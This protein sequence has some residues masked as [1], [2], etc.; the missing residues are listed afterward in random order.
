[1]ENI[2][3]YTDLALIVKYQ[4]VAEFL[5]RRNLRSLLMLSSEIFFLLQ[6]RQPVSGVHMLVVGRRFFP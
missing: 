4:V 6:L 3:C 1:M 2:K 5:S